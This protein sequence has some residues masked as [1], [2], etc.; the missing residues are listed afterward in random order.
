MST[1]SHALP[2]H[3]CIGC[4]ACCRSYRVAFH[5]SETTAY[6]GGQVPAELTESLRLHEVAMRGTSSHHP[7][8]I[9]LT[10]EPGIDQRCGIHGRHPACCREVQVGDDQ[11]LRARAAHRLPTLSID[12]IARARADTPAAGRP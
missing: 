11:C 5:W 7:R 1:E 8:C 4:A 2:R 9:A 3:V 12:E 10:G 6:P